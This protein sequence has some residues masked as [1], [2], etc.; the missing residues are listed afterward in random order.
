V[1][2]NGAS[3]AFSRY[4]RT[5]PVVDAVV[6]WDSPAS[7]SRRIRGATAEK[8]GSGGPCPGEFTSVMD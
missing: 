1:G 2:G 3:P 5:A 8:R 6:T 7:R 4:C